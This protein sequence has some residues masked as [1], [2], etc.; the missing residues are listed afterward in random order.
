MTVFAT[1]DANGNLTY[2]KNITK[3]ADGSNNFIDGGIVI[4]LRDKFKYRDARR[5]GL[6]NE[7]LRRAA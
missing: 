1:V 6:Q 3:N 4:Q 5:W 7:N 2:E